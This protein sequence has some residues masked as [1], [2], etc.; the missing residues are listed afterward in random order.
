MLF[1]IGA[2]F[3]LLGLLLSVALHELGHMYFARKFKVKVTD[4][5]IGFGPA[6]V[7]KIN[8]KGT[9][10][11]IRAIPL[12]GYIK[13]VGMFPE[14]SKLYEDEKKLLKNNEIEF[15]KIHPFKKIIIMFA[16]PMANFI[17]AIIF[18][19][20]AL[21]G[22]GVPSPSLDIKEIPKCIYYNNNDCI[23][24]TA[25]KS[26]L[27][28]NDRIIS[29]NGKEINSWEDFTIALDDNKG[30]EI[31]LLVSR[32][33]KEVDIIIPV[34]AIEDR[35]YI[36]VAP[37]IIYKR[38]SISTMYGVIVDNLFR[39]FKAIVGLPERMVEITKIV[40][41]DKERDPN[42]PIGVVGLGRIS[43]EIAQSPDPNHEKI[44][45]LLLLLAGLNMSLFVFNLL[46][47]V[48]LDGGN[49]FAAIIEYIKK[50]YFKTR[51]NNKEYYLDPAKFIYFT[52]FVAIILM[53]TS[54][55]LMIADI[56]KPIYLKNL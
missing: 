18:T 39:V 9:N 32:A 49:A 34:L 26:N 29:I 25:Y 5:M 20:I 37:E 35:G 56:I 36:G 24:G 10:V 28:A 22:L 3:L 54:L 11:G 33:N 27:K 46:P 47:L 14:S 40:F 41:T 15:Y 19:A 50:I 7:S 51:S 23:E 30:E 31:N 8:K 42:G 45:M 16:G 43:G 38:E 12:G 53:S 13:M 52:Y 2:I 4:Y 44:L 21:L 17:L 1:T 48:P 6:I 55:L